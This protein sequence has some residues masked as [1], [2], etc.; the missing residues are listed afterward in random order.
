MTDADR[1]ELPLIQGYNFSY[2]LKDPLGNILTPGNANIS[3][4][5]N[6]NAMSVDSTGLF[7]GIVPSGSVT[8]DIS[9][10]NNYSASLK[11][12]SFI[13]YQGTLTINGD[14][15]NNFYTLP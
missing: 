11:A 4:S 15:T 9:G 10:G 6:D 12:S 5:A 3:A 13:R 7:T 8:L 14:S 1:I 2:K